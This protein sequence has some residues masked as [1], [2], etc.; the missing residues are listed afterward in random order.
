[1]VDV[2]LAI[3]TYSW[4][5]MMAC[6]IIIL[7]VLIFF[8]Y[9][10]IADNISIFW[11]YKTAKVLFTSYTFYFVS[12]FSIGVLG[13]LDLLLIAV[14]KEIKKSIVDYFQF[15]IKEGI[16]EDEDNFFKIERI[17]KN[18][19]KS[20]NFF[21][22]KNLKFNK[23]SLTRKGNSIHPISNFNNDGMLIF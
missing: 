4:T 20:L 23:T 10:W 21:T 8:G 9:V 15:I 12:I 19:N 18:I 2:K 17:A 5:H 1:M 7:S 11:V 16:D 13:I 3:C 14:Q 6:S 22:K